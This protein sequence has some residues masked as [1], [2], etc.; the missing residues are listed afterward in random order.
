MVPSQIMEYIGLVVDSVRLSFSLPAEKV[1]TVMNICTTALAADRVSLR[2]LASILGNFTWAIP[3]VPYA[4]AHY[5]RMQRFYISEARRAGG[6]LDV[7]R[8]LPRAAR[9]DLQWWVDNLLKV[10]GRLFFPKVADIEIYSDASLSGWGASCNE[11]TTRGPWTSSDASRHINELYLLG[12]FFALQAFVGS[13]R[14]IAVR[15]FLDNTTAICYINKSGGTR[16]KRL[17]DLANRFS[18]FCEERK[19]S[20]E[21]VHLPGVLNVVADKE[22]RTSVDSSDWKLSSTCFKRI[23]RIWSLRIDLFSSAWNAQ[24]P[25]F[26]SWRPQPGATAVN[27]FSLNWFGIDSYAFP[28]FALI[29]KCLEKIRRERAN[30]VLICPVWTSQPWFPV[31]LEMLCDVPR[32]LRQSSKLLTSPLGEPH[33]LLSSNSLQLAAWR[34]SGDPSLSKAFR[35]EWSTFCWP[36]IDLQQSLLTIPAGGTGVIGVCKGVRIP[37]R[38]L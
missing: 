32:L 15:L 3:T 16:S 37:C 31:A 17:S 14:D 5:R 18:L 6:N 1:T 34:L 23:G 7:V 25:A 35:S 9:L 22:S 33:P 21:A 4:Q 28:P 12:A 24:L 29:S 20:V 38:L 2:E 30:L 26:V 11:V 27:A 13:S 8:Q 19:L 10:N 36:V